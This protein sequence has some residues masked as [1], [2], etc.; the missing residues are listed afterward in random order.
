MNFVR[1]FK[2]LNIIRYDYYS[3]I[4][5]YMHCNVYTVFIFLINSELGHGS[6]AGRPLSAA[7]RIPSQTGTARNPGS[8]QN[9]SDSPAGIPVSHLFPK[10]ALIQGDL[11]K[12][13]SSQRQLKTYILPPSRT[14]PGPSISD[15][16]TSTPAAAQKTS[17]RRRPRRRFLIA[18]S[19]AARST[20]L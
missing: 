8:R 15:T 20:S 3:L 7:A 10:P 12:K 2:L 14:G 19:G 5:S 9:I 18:T 17:R 16:E 1:N 6:S 13:Q 11:F 4:V